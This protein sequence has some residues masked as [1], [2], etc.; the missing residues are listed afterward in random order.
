[1]IRKKEFIVYQLAQKVLTTAKS[2]QIKKGRKMIRV[3]LILCSALCSA[4]EQ[5]QTLS[6]APRIYYIANFLSDKECDHIIKQAKPLLERS[7]VLSAKGGAI[8]PRRSSRGMFF[9]ANS[10][11]PIIKSIDRRIAKWTKLPLEHGE[12]F[13][14]LCYNK[15][16]E[17]QPHFDYFNKSQP[18]GADALARGGQRVASLILYLNNPQKGGETIF[19]KLKIA[20]APRKGGALLFF[21]VTPDGKEDPLTFHGGAPVLEGE[22]WIMTKWVRQGI[23]R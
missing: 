14:V 11:D 7:T 19:P 8:D 6:T 15:G 2:E 16:G 1:M 21:N 3:L 12:P 23:F 17:Y 9:P 13:Q 10:V 22:K 20:V 18:G 5:I 4:H